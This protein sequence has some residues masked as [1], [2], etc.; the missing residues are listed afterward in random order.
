MS[1]GGCIVLGIFDKFSRTIQRIRISKIE[2][3]INRM[4]TDGR[5]R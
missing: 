3:Q 1:G 5:K 4:D 2:P